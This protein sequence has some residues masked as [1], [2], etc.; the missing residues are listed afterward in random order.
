MGSTLCKTKG[1]LLTPCNQVHT[2]FMKGPIDVIYLTAD[3]KVIHIEENVPPY[4]FGSKVKGAKKVLE[5]MGGVS[6][7]VNI[8]KGDILI[9]KQA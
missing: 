3:N 9:F 2:H 4:R 6:R 7:E 8:K 5:L 1:L